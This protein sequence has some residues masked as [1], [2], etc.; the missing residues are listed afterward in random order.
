VE[1]RRDALLQA[2]VE[3]KL[4]ASWTQVQRLAMKNAVARFDGH[5]AGDPA[6]WG[7]A[8]LLLSS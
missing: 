5:G 3:P 1:R 2:L 7:P 8:E 4:G 6:P